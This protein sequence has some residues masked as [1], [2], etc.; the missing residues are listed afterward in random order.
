M[1]RIG[2]IAAVGLAT[3]VFALVAVSA[4]AKETVKVGFIVEVVLIVLLWMDRG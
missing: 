3:A 1:I 4:D 2:R